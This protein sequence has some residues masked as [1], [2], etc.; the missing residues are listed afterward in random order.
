MTT[1]AGIRQARTL[2]ALYAEAEEYLIRVIARAAE[3]GAEGSLRFYEGQ[4][5][6]L[7]RALGRSRAYIR[8][9]D[10]GLDAVVLA[11]IEAEYRAAY[12]PGQ[13]IPANAIS[14]PAILAAA[15]ETRSAL[16]QHN[17]E[18]LRSVNDDYRKIIQSVNTSGQISGEA[19]R[20]TLQHALNRFA[21]K[22]ITG[23]TDKAGRRW[24]IQTYAEMAIRTGQRKANTA[25]RVKRFQ[26]LGIRY[27]IVSQHKDPAPQCAPFQGKVLALGAES[28][29][30]I[31][32]DAAGEP[33]VVEVFATMAEA[34]EA[35]YKHPNCRHT[36]TAYYP[37]MVMPEVVE[38]V[39][40]AY[41]ATQRQRAME[42]RVRHWKKREAAAISPGE[43]GYARGKVREWQA[44]TREHVAGHGHLSRRYERENLRAG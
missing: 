40:G 17:M 2:A 14:E 34:L 41:E 26:E 36:E 27:V 4:Y 16:K 29:T 13:P 42:R 8:A 39:P 30:Q 38:E 11:E 9:L 22:G 5:E 33:H 43:R 28:G 23:F 10:Q 3:S 15:T 12:A 20:S 18:I 37:G 32:L 21:D 25:G 7:Q 1:P 31:V 35:G 19:M 24:G 6:A 44:A